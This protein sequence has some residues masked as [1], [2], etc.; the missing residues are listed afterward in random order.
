MHSANQSIKY[1]L[2]MINDIYQDSEN[3]SMLHDIER[4]IPELVVRST[5]P[6]CL[7]PPLSRSSSTVRCPRSEINN[8]EGEYIEAAQSNNMEACNK[9][10][11]TI[12]KLVI[13]RFHVETVLLLLLTLPYR[14]ELLLTNRKIT[15]VI[16][17]I[18]Y[19]TLS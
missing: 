6:P 18:L 16:M 5:A 19:P 9:A 2:K 3:D 7:T 14:W 4:S 15:L 12:K 1:G 10:I 13:S 17:D 8:E 11:L